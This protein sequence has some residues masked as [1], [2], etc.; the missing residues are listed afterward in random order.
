MCASLFPPYHRDYRQSWERCKAWKV[1]L[2]GS[3][4]L[5]SISGCCLWKRTIKE[6]EL[7][8]IHSS[9]RNSLFSSL[10]VK[11]FAQ[12]HQN[13]SL[14]ATPAKCKTLNK[15]LVDRNDNTL[16]KVILSLTH[17][18][19]F[20][21]IKRSLAWQPWK[22]PRRLALVCA[23]ISLGEKFFQVNRPEVESRCVHYTHTD[24]QTHGTKRSMRKQVCFCFRELLN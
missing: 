20:P 16:V 18:T 12:F 24:T 17:H 5:F 23:F 1:K 22:T 14:S 19:F 11:E 6:R 3:L 9:H 10:C 7:H 4:E 8:S 21:A 13:K 2:W 15:W